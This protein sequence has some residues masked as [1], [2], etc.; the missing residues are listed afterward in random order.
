[1]EY[2]YGLGYKNEI[3]RWGWHFNYVHQVFY[4]KT[5]DWLKIYFGPSL[6]Y[7]YNFGY[8]G[9]VGTEMKLFDRLRFDVR[10]EWT[11]QTNQ[12]QAGLIFTYQ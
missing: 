4:N 1:M 11:T 6:N 10:Y 5:A 12:L 2:N 9:I 3:D 8:G 7:V